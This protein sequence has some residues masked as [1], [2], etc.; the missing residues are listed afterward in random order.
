MT[1]NPIFHPPIVVTRA[2]CGA[3]E[4]THSLGEKRGSRG[5]IGG[6]CDPTAA[7]GSVDRIGKLNCRLF[8]IHELNDPDQNG[9]HWHTWADINDQSE[10]GPDAS[11]PSSS[12]GDKSAAYEPGLR[13]KCRGKAG[14]EQSCVP[15]R[16]RRAD[17]RSDDANL[18][19]ASSGPTSTDAP[20]ISRTEAS[21]L[22]Q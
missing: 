2:L 18:N 22:A 21:I 17:A 9:S 12:V 7:G 19:Y 1:R 15:S 6:A 3:R 20:K 13:R 10:T 8:K 16:K 5:R 11:S 4:K 14:L